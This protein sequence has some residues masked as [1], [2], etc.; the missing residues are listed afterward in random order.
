MI[1]DIPS[2]KNYYNGL[3]SKYVVSDDPKEFSNFPTINYEL[4]PIIDNEVVLSMYNPGED[5]YDSYFGKSRNQGLEEKN[6]YIINFL[7]SRLNEKT[8]IYTQF[9]HKGITNLQKY[10]IQA[11]IKFEFITGEEDAISKMRIVQSFINGDFNVL[12]LL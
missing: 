3:F 5:E 2:F 10:L 6:K 12:F 1:N 11:K 7:Q 8:C 9:I 4:I